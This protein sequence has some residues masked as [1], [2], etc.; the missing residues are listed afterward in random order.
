[1]CERQNVGIL[2]IFKKMQKN[3]NKVGL[4][5]FPFS[6]KLI[7]HLFIVY[8]LG[9][10]GAMVC[11]RSEDKIQKAALSYHVWLGGSNSVCEA[12]WQD[13]FTCWDILL[14]FISLVI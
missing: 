5:H 2:D 7:M 8:V 14:P 11:M 1:M 10:C 12:W 9:E 3:R 4:F 6:V 13:A